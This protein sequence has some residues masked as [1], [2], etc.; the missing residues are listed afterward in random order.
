MKDKDKLLESISRFRDGF[1]AKNP[2][3]RPPT[4]IASDGVFMPINYLRKEFRRSKL[5][6]S[7]INSELCMTDYE[8]GFSDRPIF[9]DDW[10]PFCAPWRAVPWLEAICGC[11][12]RYSTGSLAPE[13]FVDSAKALADLPIPAEQLWLDCMKEQ[14]GQ[15]QAGAADDCWSSPSILR[16]PSDVL[17][18]MRG[19]TEFYCDIMTDAD[20][21]DEAAGRINRLFL[22]VLDTHFSIVGEKY[23]GYGHIYGYWAPGKTIVIQEDAMGMCSPETY[24]DIFMKYN[25]DIV[26]HLGQHVLFHIHSTGFEHYKDVLSIPGIAGLQITMEANGPSLLDMLPVLKEILQKSRL[27][28]FVDH[29]FEQLPATLRQLPKEGFYLIISDKYIKSEEQFGEFISCNF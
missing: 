2:I 20:I 25:A 10:M 9:S 5:V 15:L 6:P 8:F 27:I 21:I 7:D 1:W 11:P 26:G 16:G 29:Y 13:H 17:A 22:D 19:I 3:D 18:A 4:G 14:T 28:L 12:V 24:R 23:G